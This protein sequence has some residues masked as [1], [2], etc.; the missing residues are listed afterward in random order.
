MKD[1]VRYENNALHKKAER[2]LDWRVKALLTLLLLLLVWVVGRGL[3]M[4]VSEG[5]QKSLPL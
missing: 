5:L 1:D 2:K 4:I 3:M